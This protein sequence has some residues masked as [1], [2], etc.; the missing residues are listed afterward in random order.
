MC[1]MS[2]NNAGDNKVF[3]KSNLDHYLYEFAK[4]YRKL[5]GRKAPRIELILIGGAAI[6]ENYNFRNETLFQQAI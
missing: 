1:E 3:N 6:I 5:A 2:V 4:T